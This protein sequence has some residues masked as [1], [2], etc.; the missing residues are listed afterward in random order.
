MM[1]GKN[2]FLKF[3]TW[4]QWGK[5]LLSVNCRRVN[6]SFRGHAPIIVHC[7]CLLIVALLCRLT[8]LCLC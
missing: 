7:R 3:T 4:E 6:K 8:T 5:R 2:L 1:A